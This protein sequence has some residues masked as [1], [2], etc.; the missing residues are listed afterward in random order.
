MKILIADDDPAYVRLVASR[1]TAKGIEVVTAY[2]ATHAWMTTVL[3]QPDAII[4]DTNMPAGGHEF[5]KS[6]RMMAKTAHIP[7]V[8]VTGS[9]S[10]EEKSKVMS[11][12]ADEFLPKPADFDQLYTA[13]RR[14][15]G[16]PPPESRSETERPAA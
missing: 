13:L 2:D 15:L 7:V 11:S 8:V 12:G 9:I 6:L 5:L 16:T 4:M 3:S 14:L 1:L 10:P